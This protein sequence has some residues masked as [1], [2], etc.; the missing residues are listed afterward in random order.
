MKNPFKKSVLIAV[1]YRTASD[2]GHS[3]KIGKVWFWVNK[4]SYA[5]KLAWDMVNELKGKAITNIQ[6]L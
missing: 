1:Y 2:I 6:I 5:N 4:R 3:I